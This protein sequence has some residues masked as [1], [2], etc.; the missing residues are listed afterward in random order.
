MGKGEAGRRGLLA[1]IEDVIEIA[2][3]ADAD[4]APRADDHCRLFRLLADRDDV[5]DRDGDG[6]RV[7]VIGRWGQRKSARHI[8]GRTFVSFAT[9]VR[10]GYDLSLI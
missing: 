1:A 2:G 3:Y 8:F 7:Q 5:S 10:A 9:L 6:T 4:M